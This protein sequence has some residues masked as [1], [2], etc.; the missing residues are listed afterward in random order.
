MQV[1][2]FN[3]YARLIHIL[4][5]RRDMGDLDTWYLKSSSASS[6]SSS[7]S[8][9]F[10]P[11]LFARIFCVLVSIHK[12]VTYILEMYSSFSSI[13]GLYFSRRVSHLVTQ[14]SLQ[15]TRICLPAEIQ[16]TSGLLLRISKSPRHGHV[17]WDYWGLDSTSISSIC[18]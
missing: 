13:D 4:K 17:T 10:M 15:Q 9:I 6:S 1:M 7:P 5:V 18:C 3:V 8:P 2:C 11:N 12:F 16:H 14:P